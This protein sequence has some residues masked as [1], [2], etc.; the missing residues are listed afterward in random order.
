MENRPV[1]E[2]SLGAVPAASASGIPVA[3]RNKGQGT[4]VVGPDFSV[5]CHSKAKSGRPCRA[6]AVA[7]ERNCVR[8]LDG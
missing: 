3:G 2:G 5:Y 6:K 4:P 1:V 7:G 8:H